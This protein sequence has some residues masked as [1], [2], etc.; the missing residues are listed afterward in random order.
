MSVIIPYSVLHGWL[1]RE[2][3]TVHGDILSNIDNL[4]KMA[5]S[6]DDLLKTIQHQETTIANLQKS[7]GILRTDLAESRSRECA[8]YGC[9]VRK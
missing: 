4:I 1:N 9:G 7:L 8:A 6:R 2:P 3:G 5:A